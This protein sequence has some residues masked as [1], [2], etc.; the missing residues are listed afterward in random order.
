MDSDAESSGSPEL[1]ILSLTDKLQD[2]L[3]NDGFDDL[4]VTGADH[5]PITTVWVVSD[6][7]DERRRVVLM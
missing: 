6:G 2:I 4:V 3:I 7:T 5:K 1:T